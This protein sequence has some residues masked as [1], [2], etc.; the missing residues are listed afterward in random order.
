MYPGHDNWTKLKRLIFVDFQV[1]KI[2]ENR[3]IW[4]MWIFMYPGSW[5]LE[6]IEVFDFCEF[7]CTRGTFILPNCPEM[8]VNHLKNKVQAFQ[9]SKTCPLVTK[10]WTNQE[11]EPTSSREW[12]KKPYAESFITIRPQIAKLW[13]KMVSPWWPKN[14]L[15][16]KMTPPSVVDGKTVLTLWISLDLTNRRPSYDQKGAPWWPKNEL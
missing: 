6:K 16:K 14:E 13:P 10:N 9:R 8:M 5:K 15:I 7:S 4:C 1:M 12:H 11:S 2:E 3:S